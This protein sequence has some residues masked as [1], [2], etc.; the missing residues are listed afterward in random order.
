M[1]I[2]LLGTHNLQLSFSIL[3]LIDSEGKLPDLRMITLT[4][5][6]CLL[7][8]IML[9]HTIQFI[10]Y[11]GHYCYAAKSLSS[12]LSLPVNVLAT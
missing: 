9:L 5:F 8:T 7:F 1:F 6:R 12:S 10:L 2:T 11:S 3:R 4:T